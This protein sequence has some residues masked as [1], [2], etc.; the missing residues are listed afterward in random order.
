MR[1]KGLCSIRPHARTHQ[2]RLDHA[3]LG[4][5]SRFQ[6][7][8]V[9][10]NALSRWWPALRHRHQLP[11]RTE[12]H[13][14]DAL[15]TLGTSAAYNLSGRHREHSRE[16][17]SRSNAIVRTAGWLDGYP[18]HQS[19]HATCRRHTTGNGRRIR[20]RRQDGP[21]ASWSVRAGSVS[22]G[23]ISPEPGPGRDQAI[24]SRR[25]GRRRSSRL[26][27]PTSRGAAVVGLAAK[28]DPRIDD[29]TGPRDRLKDELVV[30]ELADHERR[31]RVEAL[32][33]QAR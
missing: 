20:A 9:E 6:N 5:S 4:T 24:A 7:G 12:H 28:D 21:Q 31:V 11:G 23:T 22:R 19:C 17:L 8:F 18:W 32:G 10:H 29:L 14:Q 15:A 13:S 16:A 25:P 33:R 3:G 30:D 26:S 1:S 27:A 2:L